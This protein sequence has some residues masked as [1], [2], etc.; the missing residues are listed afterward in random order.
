MGKKDQFY[1]PQGN[2]RG[3]KG[4]TR[5]RSPRPHWDQS[6][7]RRNKSRA[8]RNPRELADDYGGSGWDHNV[9]KTSQRQKID[10]ADETEQQPT[11]Q[12][13][14]IKM[15]ELGQNPDRKRKQIRRQSFGQDCIAEGS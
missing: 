2:K 4:T 15:L 10:K 7:S 14:H 9:K 12:F 8:D 5:N 1:A 11:D 13:D 3:K 6:A